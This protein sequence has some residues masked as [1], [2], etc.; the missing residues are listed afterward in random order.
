M[1]QSSIISSFSNFVNMIEEETKILK[2]ISNI[3]NQISHSPNS[4]VIEKLVSL[5]DSVSRLEKSIDF[6]EESMDNE[7]ANLAETK[8]IIS[9]AN[10]QKT[11]ILNLNS[12]LQSTAFSSNNENT[13][14]ILTISSEEF[15]SI[16][17][18]TRSRL[19]LM[20]INDALN[21]LIEY[22]DIKSKTLKVPRKKITKAVQTLR[23]NYSKLKISDHGNDMFL[24]E[25]EIRSSK[26]FE[27][28]ESTGKTIL[29]T[30]RTL[31]RLRLIRSC[32][33]NTYVITI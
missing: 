18:S 13:V 25:T 29:H 3:S 2:S 11:S 23:E 32:G 16:S 4:N 14:P 12:H 7:L 8:R 31:R 17:K 10:F 26:I 20:Q 19:T 21:F 15:E 30:L 27:S 24:T 6:L 9:L 1:S 5:D 33:E 28:G 22:S